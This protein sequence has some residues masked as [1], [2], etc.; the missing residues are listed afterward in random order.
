MSACSLAPDWGLGVWRCHT[1]M[2]KSSASEG[3]DTLGVCVLCSVQMCGLKTGLRREITL[4]IACLCRSCRCRDWLWAVNGPR[5]RRPPW[6][7]YSG[8]ALLAR[9]PARASLK[10]PF[11]HP[12]ATLTHVHHISLARCDESLHTSR[13][14]TH[15][16]TVR[17]LI[18][19]S[20]HLSPHRRQI[21]V[22]VFPEMC[23]HCVSAVILSFMH[24]TVLLWTSV[25]RNQ[26]QILRRSRRYGRGCTFI[27]QTP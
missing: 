4:L 23:E 11:C 21:A 18:H 24:S 27:Y 22:I 3:V 26:Q 13:S 2:C 12:L 17:L 10:K 15:T 5:A 25:P 16:P 19:F 1:H 14:H 9:S 7:R 20:L 6:V 8:P